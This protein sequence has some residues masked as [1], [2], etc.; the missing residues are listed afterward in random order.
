VAAL[1]RWA[2]RYGPS[3]DDGTNPWLANAADDIRSVQE[4]WAAAMN[5]SGRDNISIAVLQVWGRHRCDG[6]REGLHEGLEGHA[7][8]GAGSTCR[9]CQ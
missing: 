2:Q 9:N 3:A 6:D 5:A 8:R 1:Q 4:L 7:Q